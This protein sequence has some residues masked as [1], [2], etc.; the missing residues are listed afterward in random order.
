MD[1]LRLLVYKL[2]LIYFFN[3][4]RYTFPDFQGDT[5][6]LA[7]NNDTQVGCTLN[8]FQMIYLKGEITIRGVLLS[9]YESLD[10]NKVY[11]F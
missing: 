8:S 11:K 3:D 10:L 6:M 1:Y 5:R 7:I 2:F 4:F 9:S